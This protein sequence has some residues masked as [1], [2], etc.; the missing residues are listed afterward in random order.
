[1]YLVYLHFSKLKTALLQGFNLIVP[2]QFDFSF[3]LSDNKSIY[4]NYY[5]VLVI[6][7]FLRFKFSLVIYYYN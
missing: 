4:A 3:L 5:V 1:M 2:F 7:L 6:L